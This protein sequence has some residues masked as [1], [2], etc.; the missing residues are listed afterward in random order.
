MA[1]SQP[2]PTK[3]LLVPHPIANLTPEEIDKMQP[4]ALKQALHAV[5]RSD[6][7]ADN[8]HQNHNSHTNS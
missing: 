5:I 3:K 8:G 7:T 2:Q 6:L 4:E 1:R